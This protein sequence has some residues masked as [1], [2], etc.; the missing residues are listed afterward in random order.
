MKIQYRYLALTAWMLLIFLFSSEIA[1]T[2]SGHSAIIVNAI[3]NTFHIGLAEGIVTFLTRK[4][5]HIFMYFVLGTLIYN[6]IKEYKL[7]IKK[8]IYLSIISALTYASLDEIHQIFVPGRSC[9]LRD[10]IIDTTASVVGILLFYL[11]Y[12]IRCTSK[13][14]KID[15]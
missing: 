2:S 1:S 9:E 12:K 4:A 13:N 11:A 5:A 3:I 8:T 6:V 10:V 15:V 7:P 14:S